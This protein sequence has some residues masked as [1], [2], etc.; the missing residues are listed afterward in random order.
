MKL[1]RSIFVLRVCSKHIHS[2][3]SHPQVFR[4]FGSV[5]LHHLQEPHSYKA[6]Q[7]MKMD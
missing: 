6:F 5:E 4:Y 2:N 3:T 1:I 7:S